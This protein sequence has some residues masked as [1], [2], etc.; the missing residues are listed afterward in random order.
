MPWPLRR[1]RPTIWLLLFAF[2]GS[3]ALVQ[4]PREIGRWH[5][6]VALNLRSKGEKDAANEKFA[7]AIAWFPK[8]P[9]LLL[10]RAEWRLEDGQR[11][12]ALADC[13]RMLELGGETPDWLQIHGKF[14]QDAGEF[15]RAVDDWKKVEQFSRR[16]G[17]PPRAQA[18][19]GL[20][21]A[22]ALAAIELDDA[23][24]NVNQSLELL[25]ADESIPEGMRESMRQ[26]RA[27]ILDTRGL[28]FHLQGRNDLA[29]VD[30]D[31]AVKGMESR[32]K[33]VSVPDANQRLS[34]TGTYEEV[35][36]S[37]PKTL[38]TNEAR[39]IAVIHYHRALVLAALD[40][41]EEAGQERA[42]ARQLIG[43]EPDETLF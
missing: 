27:A 21:Y 13:D 41:T 22:Q 4:V 33:K 30:M 25:P 23:L 40:R 5:L 2:I 10:Q 36:R 19:N 14:L 35:A 43:R 38:Q 39:E 29:I 3:Y 37:R 15:V 26:T 31:Q 16:S 24:E 17:I 9:D 42:R 6:A 11:D 1:L 32:A 12:E 28:I 20:A 34:T 8:S 7:A 18:L